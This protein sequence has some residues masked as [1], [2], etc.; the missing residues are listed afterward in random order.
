M[1][2]K[3]AT[4]RVNVA[5]KQA[6][7]KECEKEEYERQKMRKYRRLLKKEWEARKASLYGKRSNV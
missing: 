5:C 3:P 2:S 7:K 6:K 4:S 1:S